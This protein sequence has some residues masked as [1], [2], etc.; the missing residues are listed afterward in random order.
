MVLLGELEVGVLEGGRCDLEACEF[1]VV[2]LRPLEQFRYDGWEVGALDEQLEL[3]SGDVSGER[4]GEVAQTPWVGIGRCTRLRAA[5]ARNCS[6]V[7]SATSCPSARTSS[8]RA[9][10]WASSM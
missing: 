8:R 3:P 9:S 2:G 1:E 10:C 6:G 5:R 7:E 4:L